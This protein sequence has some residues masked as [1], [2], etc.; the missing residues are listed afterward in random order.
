M[1]SILIALVIGAGLGTVVGV[2]LQSTAWGV[3]CGILGYVITQIIISL[4]LRKKINAIQA[5]IQ[6]EMNADRE[7]IS[8]QLNTFQQ[9]QP[10]NMTGL[11]QLADRLQNEVS[12]KLLNSTEQF[13]VFYMWSPMLYKQI[14]AMKVQLYYQLKDYAEVDRLLPKSML[15]DPLSLAIKLVRMYKCEDKGL[16][17]FY[18]KKC[19][20]I[21]A[22]NGAFL[23]SVYAW[24]KL[25]Q[26]NSQAAVAALRSARKLSDH[27]VLIDNLDKLLNDRKKDFSNAGF[28][29][30]WYSLGLEEIKPKT[31]RRRNGPMF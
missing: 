15:L 13:K 17:A 11:K 4:I 18:N 3:T 14:N 6:A 26:Q 8:R 21:K 1:L 30:Q 9:R 25:K 27:P 19:S 20:R 22:D 16:D 28:G 5:G 7:R 24:I 31:L 29:E 23:A 2:D 12:R 10:G